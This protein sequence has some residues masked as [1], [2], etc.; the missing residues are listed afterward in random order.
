MTMEVR[1]GAAQQEGGIH[2]MHSYSK[3]LG[4]LCEERIYFYITQ[5]SKID[6]LNRH[7]YCTSISPLR[8]PYAEEIRQSR[9]SEIVSQN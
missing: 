8:S 3:A 4:N 6:T 9:L 5:A 7:N 1:S 2:D